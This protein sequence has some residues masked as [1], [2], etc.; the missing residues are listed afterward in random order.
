MTSTNLSVFLIDV[1]NSVIALGRTA[2]SGARRRRG[3]WRKTGTEA[4]KATGHFR[5]GRTVAAEKRRQRG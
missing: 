5:H 3:P 4:D 2:Q 1:F